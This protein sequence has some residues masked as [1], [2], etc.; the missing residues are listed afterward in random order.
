VNP[1][2]INVPYAKRHFQS[3]IKARGGKFQVET[4]VWELPDSPDNQAFV[5][6]IRKPLGAPT[7]QERVA[8]VVGTCIQLLNALGQTHFK[9][10]QIGERI[11]IER[12]AGE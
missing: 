8:N 12:E 10:V 2:K 11:V 4:K 6:L 7:H 1:I 3:E 5:E 9:V